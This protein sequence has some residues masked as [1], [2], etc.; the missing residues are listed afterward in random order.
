[1]DGS[2]PRASV[3]QWAHSFPVVA[4]PP[5]LDPRNNPPCTFISVLPVAGASDKWAPKQMCPKNLDI[6]QLGCSQEGMRSSDGGS[7]PR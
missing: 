4:P 1:M 2:P 7:K 3:G 5:S 6:G